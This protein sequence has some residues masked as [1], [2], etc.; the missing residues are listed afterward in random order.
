MARP[1]EQA[2]HVP[3]FHAVDERSRAD[4]RPVVAQAFLI[5]DVAE[6]PTD[7]L[8]GKPGPH[9]IGEIH[10][11]VVENA[12]ADPGIMGSGQERHAGTQARAE[13]TE[14]AISLALEPI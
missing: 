4:Y 9:D 13:D 14:A 7:M 10:G 5:Q 1:Y 12:N 6:T 8:G 11:H 2:A 3:V